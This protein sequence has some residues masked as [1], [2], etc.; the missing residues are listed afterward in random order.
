MKIIKV[1][2]N[3]ALP[4][5]D[6]TARNDAKKG[7]GVI[8]I[9]FSSKEE[10]DVPWLK[11]TVN[12]TLPYVI[13]NAFNRF[14]VDQQPNKEVNNDRMGNYIPDQVDTEKQS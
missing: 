14:H 4:D 8:E 6:F 1:E 13:V 9:K 12:K 11:I 3:M 10:K 7:E 5:I 2:S